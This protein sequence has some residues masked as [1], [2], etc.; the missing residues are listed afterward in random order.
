MVRFNAIFTFGPSI[1]IFTMLIFC[2]HNVTV[3]TL[4]ERV[5]GIAY[6]L[7]DADRVL[8]YFVDH[9]HGEMWCLLNKYNYSASAA[10]DLK[11]DDEPQPSPA[12]ARRPSMLNRSR[13]LITPA[14]AQAS[15]IYPTP[16]T[17]P[18]GDFSNRNPFS[19]SLHNKSLSTDT[20]IRPPATTEHSSTISSQFLFDDCMHNSRFLQICVGPCPPSRVWRALPRALAR[21]NRCLMH[22]AMPEMIQPTTGSST[23]KLV[24]CCVRRFWMPTDKLWRYLKPEI[25]NQV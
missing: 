11:V 13:S 23:I 6:D 5:T 24:R 3:D 14:D 20:L 2:R 7:L 18:M 15:L 25:A 22:P 1:S 8:L 9:T 17:S 12:V 16:F 4:L 10:Q 21:F 19:P